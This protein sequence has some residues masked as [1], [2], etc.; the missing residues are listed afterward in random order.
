MFGEFYGEDVVAVFN[1]RMWGSGYPE[2][3]T[4]GFCLDDGETTG[5]KGSLPVKVCQL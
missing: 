5:D 2:C 1:S 3:P 4:R